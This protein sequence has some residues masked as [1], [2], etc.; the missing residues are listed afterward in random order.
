MEL[1]ST[2]WQLNKKHLTI[3]VLKW[4]WREYCFGLFMTKREKEWLIEEINAFK[5]RSLVTSRGI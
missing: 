1:K 4:E 3:Y 2:C 5:M